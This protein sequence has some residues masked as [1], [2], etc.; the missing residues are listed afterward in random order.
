MFPQVNCCRSLSG[1]T[2]EWLPGM[3]AYCCRSLPPG[4]TVSFSVNQFGSENWLR[5]RNRARDCNSLHA[6]SFS[7]IYVWFFFDCT[8][9]AVPFLVARISCAYGYHVLLVTSI[10]LCGSDPAGWHSILAAVSTLLLMVNF[11]HPASVILGSYHPICYQ[12]V[13]FHNEISYC[14][15]WPTK[16][17]HYWASQWCRCPSGSAFLIALITEYPLGLLEGCN[18]LVVFLALLSVCAVAYSFF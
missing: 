13:W 15:L 16:D 11:H 9:W 4:D 1:R 7:I 8:D 10:A 2:E 17:S 6:F 3:L 18:Q 14:Q 5:S 12:G